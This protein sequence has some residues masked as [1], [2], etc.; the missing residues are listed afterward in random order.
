[1]SSDP[2]SLRIVTL[3]CWG[4]KYLAKYR[5]ERLSQIGDE[6]ANASPAPDIVGLQGILARTISFTGEF[7]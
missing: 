4:L 1:M 5:H 3:N 7:R 2:S 6:L